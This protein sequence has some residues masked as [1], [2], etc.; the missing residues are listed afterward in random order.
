MCSWLTRR[1]GQALK[2]F[3]DEIADF[4]ELDNVTD[5]NTTAPTDISGNV[6]HGLCSRDN[7][8]AVAF[9]LTPRAQVIVVTPCWYV[10]H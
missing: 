2:I 6:T 9:S 3:T 1:L 7:Q 8:R 10:E 5:S 4:C